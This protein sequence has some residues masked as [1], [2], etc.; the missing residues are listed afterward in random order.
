MLSSIILTMAMYSSSCRYGYISVA[1][2]SEHVDSTSDKHRVGVSLDQSP[3][4]IQPSPSRKRRLSDAAIEWEDATPLS[5]S[6]D[7]HAPLRIPK[8]R[9]SVSD[10]QPGP[11]RPCLLPTVGPRKQTVS[12][13]IPIAHQ[14]TQAVDDWLSTF[15]LLDASPLSVELFSDWDVPPTNDSTSYILRVHHFTHFIK[16]FQTSLYLMVFLKQTAKIPWSRRQFR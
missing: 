16:C 7:Y 8:R 13:P 14:T 9:L 15:G 4:Y 11:K 5:S 3:A 1:D 2:G 12:T 6:C 10:S